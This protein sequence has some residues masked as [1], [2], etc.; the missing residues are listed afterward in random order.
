MA[1]KSNKRPEQ[2]SKP[3]ARKLPVAVQRTALFRENKIAIAVTLIGILLVTWIPF[4]ST[5]DSGFTV[6]DDPDYVLYNTNVHSLDLKT[7]SYFFTHQSARN[8][9]PLTMISLAFDYHLSKGNG[10]VV[11]LE[12]DASVFH[13]VNLILHLL[14]VIL[15]FAFI[16]LLTKRNILIAAV[17]SLLF[18]IHPLHVESVAWITERKDVLYTFFFMLGLISYLRYL[19]SKKILHFLM[20]VLFF[21]LSLFS[22]PAAV[23][24]PFILLVIDFYRQRMFTKQSIFE[25]I[26]LLV[27]SVIFGVITYV[28]QSRTSISAFSSI[29]IIHRVLFVCYG[30][31]MYIYKLVVPL[32]QSVYYPYPALISS[33][34]LPS[35]FYICP[36]IVFAIAG[37]MVLSYKYTRVI[38]FGIMFYF[39]SV[40]LVLQVISIGSVI[41]SERYTYMAYIGLFY[42][43][44]WYF[45]YFMRKKLGSLNFLKYIAAFILL[46]SLSTLEILT[47]EWNLVWKDPVSL[48]T[49]VIRQYPTAVSAYVNR[50][51]A[52]EKKKNLEAAREDYEKAVQFGPDNGN[53]W[54]GLGRIHGLLGE[55]DK[56]VK[57]LTKSIEMNGTSAITY[58]NRGISYRFLKDYPKAI[59]D[60]TKALSLSRDD[61]D[62]FN[63]TKNLAFTLIQAEQYTKAIDYYNFLITLQPD[64]DDFYLNRGVC[65]HRLKHYPEAIGDFTRTIELNAKQSVAYFDLA[66]VYA[67]QKDFSKARYYTEK[68]KSMGVSVDP[69]FLK[70]LAEKKDKK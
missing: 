34:Y 13:N 23:I 2:K 38:S 30:F 67:D 7:V 46:L 19:D 40:I 52:F 47:Y 49:S 41:I 70:S 15:V 22:K 6:W 28:I 39:F 58:M 42:I 26:P 25:K 60:Y 43:V 10:G 51:E 69:A 63:I 48:W 29:S 27:L 59:D 37:L 12:S 57:A 55:Y 68:A 64:N 17:T 5:L 61:A 18:G 50:G 56:S 20:V 3:S 35:I 16:F 36:I 65:H 1:K 24:F 14:N 53:A 54:D 62:R 4:R 11:N 66:I 45:D 21:L 33:G 9:H 44:A 32:N 31:V 8:Y